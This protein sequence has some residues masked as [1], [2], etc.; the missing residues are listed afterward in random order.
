MASD[1]LR[2]LLGR[3]TKYIVEGVYG[4]TGAMDSSNQWRS[5]PRT[6]LGARLCAGAAVR[7]QEDDDE[8]AY[9]AAW[10]DGHGH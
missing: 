3:L 2:L 4:D 9:G 5:R 7:G 6:L 10:G 8:A 1:R